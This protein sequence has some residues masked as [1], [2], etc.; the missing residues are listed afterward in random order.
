MA[1]I[2]QT[3]YSN[4]ILNEHMNFDKCLIEFCS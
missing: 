1:D 4:A 3:T 2:S